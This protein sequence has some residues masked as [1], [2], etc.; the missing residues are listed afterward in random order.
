MRVISTT[1]TPGIGATGIDN[2]KIVGN[3]IGVDAAGETALVPAAG[4]SD[5]GN[6]LSATDSGLIIGGPSEAER[7]LLDSGFD[8]ENQTD[9]LIQGNFVGTDKAGTTR[10]ASEEAAAY[11]ERSTNVTVGGTTAG[12]S[13]VFAMTFGVPSG[14]DATTTGLVFQGNFVGTDRTGTIALGTGAS[15]GNGVGIAIGDTAKDALI[16]GTNPGEGNTIAFVDGYGIVLNG[17]VPQGPGQLDLFEYGGWPVR[18]RRWSTIDPSIEPHLTN[19][20]ATE[21]DGTYEGAFG[22][23][24]LEFFATPVEPA[25]S[26]YAA[27]NDLQGKTFL[28]FE[29]VTEGPSGVIDFTFSPSVPLT[30]DEFITATITPAVDNVTAN[31]VNGWV[32]KREFAR[33]SQQQARTCRCPCPRAQIRWLRGERY[34]MRS[35]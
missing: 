31:A 34:F 9:A 14:N 27:S 26:P 1:W 29:D 16:G 4:E 24:R 30:A 17:L 8:L 25:G 6:V 19:V 15:P 11:V 23:Y 7:N 35:P 2:L 21:I 12:A 13:N 22:D 28:G 32:L 20:T 18:G 10:V 3:F 5:E 33:R